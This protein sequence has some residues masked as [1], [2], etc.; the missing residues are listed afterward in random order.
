MHCRREGFFLSGTPLQ[1]ASDVS[2]VFAEG[3][4]EIAKELIYILLDNQYVWA[5]AMDCFFRC[6]PGTG[7]GLSQSGFLAGVAF[8]V[9]VECKFAH[10]LSHWG[11]SL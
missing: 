5:P 3:L 4:R 7:M 8:Y 10:N 11:I 2:S 6:I 9:S 1:V